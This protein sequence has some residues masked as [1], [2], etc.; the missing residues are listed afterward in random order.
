MLI[1]LFTPK[2]G[3]EQAFF[4]AQSGEYRRLLGQ[5]PGWIGNRLGRSVDGKSFVNVAVFA[6]LADYNAWRDSAI[7]E[8]HLDIIRPFVEKSEPGMY[9]MVYSAGVIP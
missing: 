6:S 5:I 8:E 1:N 4:E 3:M 2:A 9:E 7:F